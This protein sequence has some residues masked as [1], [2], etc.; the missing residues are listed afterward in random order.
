[1]TAKI[2]AYAS[3]MIV[4]GFCTAMRNVGFDIT[5]DLWFCQSRYT[6]LMQ[7]AHLFS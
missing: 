2:V 5:F 6:Y 7:R 4:C 1:M 3:F